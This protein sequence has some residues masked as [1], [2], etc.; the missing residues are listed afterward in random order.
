[1][2]PLEMWSSMSLTKIESCPTPVSW[3]G[4]RSMTPQSSSMSLRRESPPCPTPGNTDR[5]VLH[6]YGFACSR[7]NGFTQRP[8]GLASFTE[9]NTF[10]THL[11]CCMRQY[12][13]SSIPWLKHSPFGGWL[14]PVRGDYEKSCSKCDFSLIFEFVYKT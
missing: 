11:S 14:F 1:M 9:H 4:N 5:S 10:E 6:P 2:H 12:W 7:R 13:L 8:F 3:D